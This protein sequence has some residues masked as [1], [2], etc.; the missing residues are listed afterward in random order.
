MAVSEAAPTA[1]PVLSTPDTN[2]FETYTPA[3]PAHSKLSDQQLTFR[4]EVERTVSEIR[5]RKWRRIALQFPDHML[6]DAPRV[7]DLLRN[8]L[9]SLP[10]LDADDSR[11][12]V[13]ELEHEIKS[14]DLSGNGSVAADARAGV[15]VP[16]D[17]RLYILGDTSYG[18][19]CVDEI[20]AEHVSADVVIHYG[21]ACLSP[22]AR[23]P[24]LHIFTEQQL[25]IAA[26][27]TAF[28][29]TYPTKSSKVLL[30]ADVTFSGKIPHVHTALN[31]KGYTNVFATSVVHDPA[32]IIPNR[33]IPTDLPE[34]PEGQSLLQEW[35]LF[36][37][38]QPPASLLLTLASRVESINIYPTS[39]SPDDTPST[40]CTTARSMPL[41]R[42]RYA[43][44]TRLRTASILGI[45]INTLSVSSTLPLVARL[46]E[47]IAAAGKKSYI[48]VVGKVNAAKL[49][50]FAEVDGWVVVGCWESSL[51]DDDE[52]KGGSGWW[53]PC[54][55]PWELELA[56]GEEGVW[57]GDWST[58]LDPNKMIPEAAHK[59]A[60]ADANGH[61]PDEIVEA[62]GDGGPLDDESEDE[63]PE[64]DLRTGRYVSN[65]RPMRKAQRF[66]S[67]NGS[68]NSNGNAL[69]RRAKGDLA[70]INGEASPGAA[71]LR[72][73]RTWKGLGSDFEIAYEDEKG[74]LIE[75]GRS[76]VAR[77]YVHDGTQNRT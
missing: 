1:A 7:Y 59:E 47:M 27:V 24:V 33:T 71:F 46:R 41:L 75:E 62:N 43:L 22:T 4:Y 40:T 26:V 52:G 15:K 44:L 29:A 28:E 13:E 19:C 74:S 12:P 32:S 6:P 65:S 17:E 50:N 42:R 67:A 49:A 3:P 54:V 8:R 63:P 20:A 10:R 58:L 60:E 51:L 31:E 2:V 23:L 77:G 5:R 55:T 76:G 18:A 45:L 73:K 36:H 57:R 48:V 64:F 66:S 25:D 9:R 35:S 11:V 21:R 56:L 61:A 38:S 68:A 69:T 72:E 34:F 70:V 14:V 30:V 53:K 37:I 39:S 16:D